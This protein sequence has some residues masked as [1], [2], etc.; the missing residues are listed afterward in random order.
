MTQDFKKSKKKLGGF[1]LLVT[2]EVLSHYP[3]NDSSHWLKEDAQW[4][5]DRI[6]LDKFMV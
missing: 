4:L 1:V 3:K 6:F 2:F 5:T